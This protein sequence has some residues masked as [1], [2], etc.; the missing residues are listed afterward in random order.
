MPTD[1]AR[2]M[3]DRF[4]TTR[5]SIVLAASGGDDEARGAMDSLCRLYWP[6][7]YA[8]IRRRGHDEEAAR[9]LTQSFIVRLLEKGPL[10]Q[11]ERERGRFRTFLL[12]CLK[13][14][15]ANQRDLEM[16]RKRG[17][18]AVMISIDD[19]GA[20]ERSARQQPA[21]NSTP[22]TIFER[23]WALEV[24]Q[25]AMTR[26]EKECRREGSA[27][28]FELLKPYLTRE[29]DAPAY[30]DVSHELGI[31]EG[32]V[33][34]AVHRL[35]ERFHHCLRDQVSLT[36]AHA[37]DISDEIRHLITALST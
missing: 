5:L 3:P 26:V 9:D 12:A 32:A 25:Q 11:F 15:L 14:F 28:R 21:D 16:A 33:K 20:F 19:T 6:P 30:R 24:L 23:Q 4:P 10:R 1:P 17:G 2:R 35:R 29:G 37:A 8:F 18:G 27:K 13:H 31:T 7:L 22:E 34:V 36:V